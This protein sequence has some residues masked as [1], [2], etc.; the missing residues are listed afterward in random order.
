[1][2]DIFQF[3]FVRKVYDGIDNP[4]FVSDIQAANQAVMSALIALLGVGPT[5]FFIISGFDYTPGAP[6]SYAPGTFYL[7]GVIYYKG[8]ATQEGLFLGGMTTDTMLQ[9]FD[10]GTSKNIYTLFQG[11]AG[12]ANPPNTSPVLAGNMNA[13]RIGSK[14]MQSVLAT[15]STV[16]ATLGAAAFLGIGTV[17]GTVAAGDDTRFGYSVAQINAMF[18]KIIDVLIIGSTN[19]N[20]IPTQP[21]DPAT[22]MYVDGSS[23][24]KCLLI[25]S[26]NHTTNA[27]TIAKQIAVPALVVT[28]VKIS[29]GNY[30]ITHNLGTTN[31]FVTAISKNPG[32]VANQRVWHV[33]SI[34]ISVNQFQL[35]TSDDAASPEGDF[36][37]QIWTY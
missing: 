32:L 36:Y 29:T 30:V 24:A 37:F 20:F 10:D 2:G 15:V 23:A 5:D 8:T 26:Y 17:A 11:T 25:G 18:A 27:V 13:Y 28:G 3:P 6:G 33:N 4:R 14:Y 9:P 1:M 22:K 7:N 31:Y 12:A 21:Y 35:M 34:T 19:N 16:I